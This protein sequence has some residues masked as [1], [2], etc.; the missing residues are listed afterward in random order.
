[1]KML[2]FFITNLGR[3]SSACSGV[4]CSVVA[5]HAAIGTE[6]AKIDS[7]QRPG[8]K[9]DKKEWRTITPKLFECFN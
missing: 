8:R 5:A 1:M 9:D 7:K 4:F 3:S 2:P 6:P